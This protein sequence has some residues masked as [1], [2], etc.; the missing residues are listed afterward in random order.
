MFQREAGNSNSLSMLP[1]P[2]QPDLG[3]VA[4]SRWRQGHDR[5]ATPIRSR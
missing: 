1:D 2:P 4:W 3:V 5:V